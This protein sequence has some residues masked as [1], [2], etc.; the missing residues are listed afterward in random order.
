VP[1]TGQYALDHPMLISTGQAAKDAQF[2]AQFQEQFHLAM[3]A[4]L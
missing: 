4:Y 2:E 3:P 1:E